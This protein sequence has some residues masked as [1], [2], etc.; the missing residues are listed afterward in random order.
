MSISNILK[1]MEIVKNGQA[2]KKKKKKVRPFKRGHKRYF[3]VNL[4]NVTFIK[5]T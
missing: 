4:T 2:K 5:K 3:Y 1:E